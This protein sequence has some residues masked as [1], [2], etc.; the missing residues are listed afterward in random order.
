MTM[1]TKDKLADALRELGLDAMAAKA[2]EGYYH[3]YLSPLPLPELQL[4]QDLSEAAKQRP[5]E[6]QAFIDL[7]GRI[8]DG[9]FESSI[10][11]SDEWATSEDGQ[12]AFR[13]LINGRSVTE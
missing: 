4:M 1:H 12:A 3:D 8:I 13:S 6:L 5:G 7:H 9:D 10:E 11:E 2:A